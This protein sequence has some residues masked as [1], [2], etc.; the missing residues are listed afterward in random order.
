MAASF[1][2]LDYLPPWLE[3]TEST[4]QQKTAPKAQ[5]WAFS[6]VHPHTK[7]R[8]TKKNGAF[9]L[10]WGAILYD[11]GFH[12]DFKWL[13][14]LL[15]LFIQLFSQSRA[16]L[17]CELMPRYISSLENSYWCVKKIGWNILKN[18]FKKNLNS[19][20]KAELGKVMFESVKALQF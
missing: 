4:N 9:Y 3:P 19:F 11:N 1:G 6:A 15:V 8:K 5:Y 14:S 16:N 20:L 18:Q 10:S 7:I 17:K 13:E 12:F 2:L